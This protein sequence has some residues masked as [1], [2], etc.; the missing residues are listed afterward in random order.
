[1]NLFSKIDP[2]ILNRY[3]THLKTYF[4]GIKYIRKLNIYLYGV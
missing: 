4:G 3:L 2:T 1:M